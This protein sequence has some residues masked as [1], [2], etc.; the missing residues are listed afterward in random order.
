MASIGI[1]TVTVRWP[2]LK[3]D[4]LSD[5]HEAADSLS[6]QP[7]LA[8]RLRNLADRCARMLLTADMRSEE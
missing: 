7:E 6:Y 4:D 5:L 8:E 3:P 2:D 1:L